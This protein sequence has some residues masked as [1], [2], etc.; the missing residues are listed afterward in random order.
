M[1]SPSMN[2]MALARPLIRLIRAMHAVETRLEAALEPVGL[3]LAKLGALSKLVEAG[4][5]L[6]LGN[7][8][9][10]LSCVRSNITQLVDRLEVEKMV[11]RIHDPNDRRSVRAALTEEGRARYAAGV[12][13]MDEAEKRLFGSMSSEDRALLLE[14]LDAL[15]S[16]G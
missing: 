6:P 13:A 16:A 2:D 9:E 14:R 7:L 4:E 10:R 8:A 12:A 3:S 11:V 1:Y 5:P 15:A